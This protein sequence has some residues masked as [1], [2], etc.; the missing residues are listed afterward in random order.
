MKN[1]LTLIALLL[2]VGVQGAYTQKKSNALDYNY[3][4][5]IEILEGNGNQDE[6]LE[7]L[8]K[9]ITETPK[10]SD[11][12]LVRARINY[13]KAQYDKALSDVNTAF[14]AYKKGAERETATAFASSR[15]SASSSAAQR[16]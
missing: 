5:A 10:H 14:K 8:D 11:A 1:L 9:Q 3:K 16:S 7:W 15:E 12:L 4:R 13:N 2:V 6:A